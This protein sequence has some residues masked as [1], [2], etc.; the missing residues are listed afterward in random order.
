MTLISVIIPTFNNARFIRETVES[1]LLQQNASF[2]I[3]VVDDGSTDET[4]TVLAP[5][6]DR[7]FYVYQENSGVSAARNYG[8]KLAQG[9][10]VVFLDGDDIFLAGKLRAQAD[11]L[12]KQ[13]GLGAVH[14]G[15]QLVDDQGRFLKKVEPWHDASFL[16]LPTWL[17]WKP[18][19]LGAMMFRREWLAKIAGFDPTLRHSEDVDFVWRLSLQGCRFDWLPQ[20]TVGYRQ[21]ADNT[22]QNGIQQARDMSRLLD[23]FFTRPDLPRYLRR[24]E[25]RVRYYTLLWLVWHLYR[26][27]YQS[28]IVIYLRQIKTHIHH[29]PLIIAQHWQAQLSKHASREGVALAN[30]SEFW[31]HFRI[32]LDVDLETWRTIEQALGWWLDVWWYYVHQADDIGRNNLSKYRTMS[33]PELI[34]LIQL[35]LIVSPVPVSV[36]DIHRVWNDIIS[37]GLIDGDPRI[38]VTALYLTLF[39]Q[40]LLAGN[41]RVSVQALYSAIA[42]G[43]RLRAFPA[44]KRFFKTSVFYFLGRFESVFL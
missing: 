34:Q 10:F 14:S 25:G 37:A 17:M 8:L 21:H 2:E 30:L 42:T 41:Y 43:W 11:F 16:D 20:L 36:T 31:S 13:P 28:E 23:K 44:W 9:E 38:E 18:V 35:C 19:F 22:M 12:D 15:W 3:I 32:A 33:A 4:K 29:D 40:A 26:T 1:V 39:G 27:G 7:I 6:S 5:Y 24:L